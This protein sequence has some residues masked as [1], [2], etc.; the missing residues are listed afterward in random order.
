MV[1][2]ELSKENVEDFII[3]LK[4]AF[5]IEP[6]RMTTDHIDEETI[7]KAV[8]S[9]PNELS[10]SLLA[11]E[12]DQIVGR[13]EFHSY[14]CIQDAYR[15]AYVN[16]VYTLPAYRHRGVAQSLFKAFEK[17][18]LQEE[19]NQYFLIQADNQ[20][21]SRFYKAFEQATSSKEIILRKTIK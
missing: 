4:K 8:S 12:D 7:I 9:N 10:R 3:Y 1:I 6:D 20:A 18:C 19:I 11:Y 21:A 16:W 13:L 2:K 14:L 17:I 15:M 5:A